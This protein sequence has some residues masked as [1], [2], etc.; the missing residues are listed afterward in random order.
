MIQPIVVCVQSQQEAVRRLVD[1]CRNLDGTR[2]KVIPLTP[3]D[4]AKFTPEHPSNEKACRAAF[5]LRHGALVMRGKPF[6]WLEHDSIPLKAGWAK[7]LTDEYER[8]GKA[9]LLSSDTHP[10]FDLVGG[11][12]VYH[13]DT[14]W[15]IPSNI[16]PPHGSVSGS[17]WDLWMTKRLAPLVGTTP[18]IQ[19]SYG[20]YDANGVPS[21]HR[22]PADARILRGE[23]VL[24]HRDP[25]QDLIERKARVA[26]KQ[27]FYHSGDLGDV[28]YHLE[29][30]RRLGGGEL[31]LGTDMGFPFP[32]HCR[33]PMT[34]RR[35]ANLASLVRAQPYI[36]SV[37]HH[38]GPIDHSWI[39][40]NRFRETFRGC[41]TSI[42]TSLQR[43]G[44]RR[45]GLSVQDETQPWLEVGKIKKTGTIAVARSPRYHNDNFPWINIVRKHRKRIVFIGLKDEHEAFCAQFGRVKY[46]KTGSLFDV[47]NTIG[48]SSLFIGNQSCPYAIAEGLKHPSV[49]ECWPHEPNCLFLRQDLLTMTTDFDRIDQFSSKY[50]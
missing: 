2:V 28:I 15:M 9:F 33:E 21:N 50:L 12:G 16:A 43:A 47:A 46:Q 10:P 24:F 1:Y 3:E 6:I 40:L 31:V 48:S 45:F 44:L 5:S 18:L 49:L 20:N 26:P 25:H 19:H 34:P 22:F 11:I 17:G 29:V 7:I 41:S 37:R 27:V 38:A 36:S 4:D 30:I 14:Y 13:G 35:V 32:S 42:C 23:T 8:Q 39:N